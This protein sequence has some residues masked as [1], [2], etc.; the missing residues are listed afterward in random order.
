VLQQVLENAKSLQSDALLEA[1]KNVN[2]PA[3][4]PNLYIAKPKGLQF[5]EDRL[6]KDGSAMFIQWTPEQAQQVVFPKEFAQVPPR[7]KS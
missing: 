4:D 1:L 5:A 7:P 6:L 3:G 2:I